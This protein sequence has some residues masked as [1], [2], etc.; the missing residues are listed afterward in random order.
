MIN[1]TLFWGESCFLVKAADQQTATIKQTLG[2]CFLRLII[3][4][5]FELQ[6]NGSIYTNWRGLIV[7]Q[8]SDPLNL[9]RRVS[10]VTIGIYMRD[11]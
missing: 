3:R 11:S 10:L 1:G 9:V 2:R 4:F 6:T 5:C 7:W 8:L